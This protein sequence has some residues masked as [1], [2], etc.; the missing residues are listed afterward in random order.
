MAAGLA[1]AA[2]LAFAA[3]AHDEAPGAGPGSKQ[4][5]AVRAGQQRLERGQGAGGLAWRDP[6]LPRARGAVERAGL[7]DR[8]G[9]AAGVQIGMG[10]ARAGGGVL[11]A[12]AD[13]VHVPGGRAVGGNGQQPGAAGPAAGGGADLPGGVRGGGAEGWEGR[14]AGVPAGAGLP[15]VNPGPAGGEAGGVVPGMRQDAGGEAFRGAA[16][17]PVRR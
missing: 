12:A 3:W 7:A 9:G 16:G 2:G 11:R 8:A 17:G 5:G 14:G 10:P 4:G 1:V 13:A 6:A 15:E